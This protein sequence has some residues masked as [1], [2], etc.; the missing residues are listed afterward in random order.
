MSRNFGG[1][2]NPLGSWVKYMNMKST[3]DW[4]LYYKW[5]YGLEQLSIELLESNGIS[6][7]QAPNWFEMYQDVLD[8]CARGK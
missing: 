8:I 2:K 5:K 6:T 4:W 7:I 1:R 3:K